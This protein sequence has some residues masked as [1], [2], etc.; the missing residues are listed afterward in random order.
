MRAELTPQRLRALMEAIAQSA[1]RRAF[2]VFFV[3]GATAVIAG[4]R[5]MSVDA[6]L[7]AED[8]AVFRDIQ[9]IKERLDV[10]G[11]FARPEQ[12]VP[13]L[14]GSEGRHVFV[15]AVGRV[16]YYHYDPYSQVFAKLVRGLERDVEDA[17]DFLKSG[18]VEPGRLRSLVEAIPDSAY[19]KYPSLSRAAATFAVD[20]FLARP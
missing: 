8:D 6:D 7:F 14:R 2:R 13:P 1:P 11:E 17:R 16:S 9:G 4:W 3:G 12:F 10:N 20:A 19:A 18:M 15:E 5:A